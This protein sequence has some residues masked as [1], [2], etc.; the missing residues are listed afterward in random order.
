MRNCIRRFDE[1][2][3][4]KAGKISLI[5]FEQEINNNFIC[6]KDFELL[7]FNIGETEKLRINLYN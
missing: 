7:K 5:E 1:T 6:N 4:E 2:L 3:C